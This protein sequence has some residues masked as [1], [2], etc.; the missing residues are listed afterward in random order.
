MTVK[1]LKVEVRTWKITK[2][3]EGGQVYGNFEKLVARASQRPVMRRIVV[4]ISGWK[5]STYL[6]Q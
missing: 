6:D 5:K 2:N 4:L 1:L 3:S